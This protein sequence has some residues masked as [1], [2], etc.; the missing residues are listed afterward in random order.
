MDFPDPLGA[1][2]AFHTAGG[3]STMPWHYA[4]KVAAMEYKTLRFPGHAQLMRAI[5]DLGLLDLDE[6]AV[7]GTEVRPR[8]VFV[9]VVDG[10]LRRPEAPDVVALKVVATGTKAGR[11]ATETFRLLDCYDETHGIS[12][13]MRTTGYSLA[14]TALMQVD[15]RIAEPGVRPAYAAVPFEPYA[16][17]LR[18]RGVDIAEG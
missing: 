4:G 12:A 13:M 1:L 15:G 18:R 6:V 8:D 2:E 9:A 17:E 10:K 14:I 3:I 11:P 16:E 5:R 7:A